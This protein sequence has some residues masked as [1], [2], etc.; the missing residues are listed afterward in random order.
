MRPLT[1]HLPKPLISVAG[2]ALIDWNLDWLAAGGIT[3]VVINSSYLAEK[4]EAHL[5]GRAGVTIS[6][7]G[8][9]PLETGGG[10]K[11]ALPWLG[12][13]PFLTMNSD[14]ILPASATHP[15][16][17]LQAQWDDTVDFLLLVVPRARAIGWSG[18]GDFVIDDA[19]RVR[20]P[21]P[22]EDAPVIFTGVELMHP[23]VFADA[24]DGAFSL[25]RLWA[26]GAEGWFPRVRAVLHD[27]PWLNVGD[28]D[29]L[30]V[31]EDYFR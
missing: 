25:S 19:G 13:G 30:R 29:G 20:R 18:N 31:A 24:P 4:L 21:A 17:A 2:K 11:Q 16:Q 28:L 27:G 7:E 12:S 8:S 14:A 6:R 1:E 15:V 26:R 22:G 5:A 3:Q 23:R 9:P 10:V